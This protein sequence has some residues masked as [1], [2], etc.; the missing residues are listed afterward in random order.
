MSNDYR[1]EWKILN[2]YFDSKTLQLFDDETCDFYESMKR[3]YRKHLKESYGN[4][5]GYQLEKHFEIETYPLI[6]NTQGHLDRDDIVNKTDWIALLKKYIPSLKE[7]THTTYKGLCPFHNEKTPS[8]SFNA[9]KKLWYCFG[10][11]Q[12]GDMPSFL[13][14]AHECTFL[15]ALRLADSL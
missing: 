12:G 4:M 13:M 14:K 6:K 11:S 9:E 2:S 3:I 15:E 10:E 5:S 8:F 7:S 1:P